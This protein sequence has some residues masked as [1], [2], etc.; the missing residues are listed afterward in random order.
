MKAFPKL[1]EVVKGM[2]ACAMDVLAGKPDDPADEKYDESRIAH[3]LE[4][5]DDCYKYHK[6]NFVFNIAKHSEVKSHCISHFQLLLNVCNL[7]SM[8]HCPDIGNAHRTLC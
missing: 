8:S 2:E 3:I 6:S 5:I 4:R 7:C 1:A